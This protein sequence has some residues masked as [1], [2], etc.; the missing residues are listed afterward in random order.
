MKLV[1][2]GFLS[3]KFGDNKKKSIFSITVSK[4]VEFTLE[5]QKQKKVQKVPI[6]LLKNNKDCPKKC[7]VYI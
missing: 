1:T 6:F 4:L 3:L 5:K 7:L 2:S